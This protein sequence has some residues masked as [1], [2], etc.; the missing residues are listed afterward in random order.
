VLAGCHEVETKQVYFRVTRVSD[1]GE[2][3]DCSMMTLQ[4]IRSAQAILTPENGNPV[5]GLCTTA[6]GTAATLCDPTKIFPRP[7]FDQLNESRVSLTIRGFRDDNCTIP[8][9]DADSAVFDVADAAAKQTPVAMSATCTNKV[10]LCDQFLNVQGNLVG[11]PPDAQRDPPVIPNVTNYQ[12]TFG[13][14]L[15]AVDMA[16]YHTLFTM[17]YNPL[18]NLAHSLTGMGVL[19]QD[20]FMSKC[21]GFQS[22][23]IPATGM[24]TLTCVDK[25]LLIGTVQPLDAYYLSTTISDALGNMKDNGVLLGQAVRDGMGLALATVSASDST[26]M[27]LSPFYYD[28]T[29]TRFVQGG[30]AKTDG[31]GVFAVIGTET[32]GSVVTIQVSVPGV[33]STGSPSYPVLPRQATVIDFPL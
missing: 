4:C 21:I 33:G 8:A 15:F 16:P 17:A 30:G 13:Y 32:T 25:T 2:L 29:N 12:V 14:A 27:T 18:P 24:T 3:M 31:S 28:S 5:V 10:M 22:T 7:L 19:P 1:C 23:A 20:A 9:F 6:S 26:G 11:W